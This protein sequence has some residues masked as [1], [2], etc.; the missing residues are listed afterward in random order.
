MFLL[1]HSN[2]QSSHQIKSRIKTQMQTPPKTK[3]PL[4]CLHYDTDLQNQRTSNNSHR[5]RHSFPR[6]QGDH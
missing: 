6:V 1:P 5:L 4:A 2:I 3:I